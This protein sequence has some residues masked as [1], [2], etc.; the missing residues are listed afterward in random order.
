MFQQNR[1]YIFLWISIFVYVATLP[2]AIIIFNYLESLLTLPVLKLIPVLVIG[3]I[4]FLYTSYCYQRNVGYHFLS[5]ILP[6]VLLLI[7]VVVLEK[8]TIKYLHIPEYLFLTYLIYIALPARTTDDKVRNVIL[9]AICSCLFGL[10]DEVHHGIHPLRYFGWKDMLINSVGSCIGLLLIN[11][12]CV[13]SNLVGSIRVME[14]KLKQLYKISQWPVLGLAIS[15]VIAGSSLFML[16]QY[17]AA[18]GFMSSYP[19]ILNLLNVMCVIA[20]AFMVKRLALQSIDDKIV[21]ILPI[22]IMGVLHALIVMA[23]FMAIEFK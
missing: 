6:S 7:G 23:F 13:E 22:T 15:M 16:F 10:V 17:V 3:F 19:F 1:R 14:V 9:S 8:N 2:Y 20:S 21:L 5:F 12:L 11:S 18:M 4:G